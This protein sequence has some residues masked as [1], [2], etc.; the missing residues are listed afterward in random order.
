MISLAVLGRLTGLRVKLT[1]D[2][3]VVRVVALANLG[4]P[5]TIGRLATDF[6]DTFI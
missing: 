5:G 2:P 3:A 4:F 6:M 1:F